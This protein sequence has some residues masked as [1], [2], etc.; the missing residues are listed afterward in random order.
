MKNTTFA[1]LIA[2]VALLPSTVFAVTIT[3]S[4][5]AGTH[6][7]RGGN[8]GLDNGVVEVDTILSNGSLAMLSTGV[9]TIGSA[10]ST[11]RSGR[12]E[13]TTTT[14]GLFDDDAFFL[15][16]LIRSESECLFNT[17]SGTCVPFL[18]TR[19]GLSFK[20]SVDTASTLFLT[21]SWSGGTGE[22]GVSLADFASVRVSRIRPTGG[23]Q[24]LFG[25][26]TN[27]SGFIDTAGIISG[28]V[29]LVAGDEY[30]IG[31]LHSTRTAGNFPDNLV[32]DAGSIMFGGSIVEASANAVAL[33]ARLDQALAV[34]AVPLPAAGWM[35]LAGFGALGAM[36]RRKR[37]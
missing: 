37:G 8:N 3:T 24:T 1:M 2:G 12:S 10:G 26:N 33:N 5:I 21:G 23:F 27:N 9:E 13:Q 14:Q 18:D 34:S 28:S 35:L 16:S 15:R 30:E 22:T 31:F 20:I 25:I 6:E 19:A 17:S 36:R 7:Y 11:N 4:D 32:T 29:E